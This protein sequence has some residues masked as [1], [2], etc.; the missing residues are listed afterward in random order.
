MIGKAYLADKPMGKDNRNQSMDMAK[1]IALLCII[2]VHIGIPVRGAKILLYSFHLPV[3]FVASGWFFNPDSL[4]ARSF[5]AYLKYKANTL[6]KPYFVLS[7]IVVLFRLIISGYAVSIEVL[8]GLLIQRRYTTLWFLTALF[9]ANIIFFFIVKVFKKKRYILLISMALS[10]VF[11]IYDSG[12]GVSIPWNLD[13][14]MISLVFMASG[15]IFRNRIEFITSKKKYIPLLV[16]CSFMIVC[17]GLTVINYKLGF[18]TFEMFRNRY[19]C[20]PVTILA[21][22]LGGFGLILI[23]NVI[24]IKVISDLGENSLIYF[25]LHQAI[26]Q[27]LAYKMIIFFNLENKWIIFIFAFC[28]VMSICY[29]LDKGLDLLK[30]KQWMAKKNY[31]G[32]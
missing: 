13:I 11:I 22:V 20:F 6:L 12:V 14:A 10:C 16:G 24:K 31:T 18:E 9:W 5:M 19:G 27:A 2:M 29:V 32:S 8:Q 4:N 28:V 26:G 23:C 17:F 25:G 30:I 3:F 7:I 1:G 15:Y 21:A